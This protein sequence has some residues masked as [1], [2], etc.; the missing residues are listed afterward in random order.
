MI[1]ALMIVNL[2]AIAIFITLVILGKNPWLKVLSNRLMITCL[3][4]QIVLYSVFKEM[5]MLL[6]VAIVIAILG[7]VDVQFLSVFLRKKGDL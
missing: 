7:F 2:L 6:D 3:V 1:K 4:I 5:E